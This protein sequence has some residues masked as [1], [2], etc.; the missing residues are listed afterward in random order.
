MKTVLMASLIAAQI[1]LAA[2]PATAADLVGPRGTESQRE[3]AFLG[4]RMRLKLGG[5]DDKAVR[6]GL[7]LAPLQ[8]SRA[9]DGTLRTRLGEGFE[10][11]LGDRGKPAL[12]LAGQPV[13]QL[14][15]GRSGKDPSG[16]RQGV[17]D[18]AWVAIGIGA[19]VLIVLALGVA[20]TSDNDCI[21]SE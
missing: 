9:I 20:C 13:D 7:A 12:S 14:M 1:G 21:P 10:L 3:G 4:A 19:V 17:S 16:R 18:L 11:G 6:A 15:L 2:Q 8:Q 5:G